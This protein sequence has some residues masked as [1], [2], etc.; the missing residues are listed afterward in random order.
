MRLNEDRLKNLIM[1][2][3]LGLGCKYI[4]VEKGIKN[5][6]IFLIPTSWKET[7]FSSKTAIALSVIH[8][9]LSISSI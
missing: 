4:D 8:P 6:E 9:Y 2:N 3:E 7:A 1:D 5:G